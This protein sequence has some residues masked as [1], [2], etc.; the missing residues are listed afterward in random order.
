M[1]EHPIK[2]LMSTAMENIKGMIDVNAIVGDAVKAP[3]GSL[4]I[5]ISK[6]GFG[7]AA[8]GTEFD[9]GETDKIGSYPFGGG[10]GGGVSISPVAFLV[11]RNGDIRLLSLDNNTHLLNR[12]I[13]LTPEVVEKIQ[14]AI[15]KDSNSTNQDHV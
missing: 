4:I 8:G 14:K 5:P 7:F 3:D 1:S 6:V 10:S 9:I 15:N 2:S 11:I 12:I 13:D